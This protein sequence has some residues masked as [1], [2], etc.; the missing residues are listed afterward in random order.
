MLTWK[1][2]DCKLTNVICDSGYKS[3]FSSSLRHWGLKILLMFVFLFL[4][5]LCLF[6]NMY[7]YYFLTLAVLHSCFVC[8]QSVSHPGKCKLVF[9]SDEVRV[10][11][12]SVT[13]K[14]LPSKDFPDNTTDL[15][16]NLSNLSSITSDDLK[17]LS[18]LSR[19]SLTRNQLRTLP[20]DL[21]LGLSN[22]QVLDLTGKE[23]VNLFS[24]GP[25]I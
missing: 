2:L 7:S 22:L 13:F 19:L 14:Q 11:C 16:V 12:D 10:I 5:L 25:H 24:Y 17:I 23:C 6:I 21:L 9:S 4:F 8:A 15:T 3:R 20:A 18:H 1:V